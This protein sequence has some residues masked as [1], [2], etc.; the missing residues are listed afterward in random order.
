VRDNGPGIPREVL[1]GLFEPFRSVGKSGGTG[2]GLAY[3]QRVMKAFGGEVRCESV[4]GQFTEFSL[5]FPPIGEDAREE[6]RAA[7]L[8]AARWRWWASACCWSRTTPRS[9]SP[10]A[11]SCGRWGWWSTR[12]R[13]ASARWS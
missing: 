8:E 10:P 5:R 2:L 4:L 6:H 9:A 1:A 12:R 13:T 11:T 3:C 7:V